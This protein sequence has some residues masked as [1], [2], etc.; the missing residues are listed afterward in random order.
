MVCPVSFKVQMEL[1]VCRMTGV[2]AQLPARADAE[3]P[4]AGGG[5]N[6]QLGRKTSILICCDLGLERCHYVFSAH[7]SISNPLSLPP[8]KA[9]QTPTSE[10][11]T[12]ESGTSC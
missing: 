12:K 9:A 4:R 1:T 8:G 5:R 6:R 11:I 10:E 2:I 7:P 3:A